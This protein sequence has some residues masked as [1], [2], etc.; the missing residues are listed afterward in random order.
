MASAA[1]FKQQGDGFKLGVLQDVGF[2]ATRLKA[3]LA[4]FADIKVLLSTVK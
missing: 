1:E 2:K 3:I 4:A